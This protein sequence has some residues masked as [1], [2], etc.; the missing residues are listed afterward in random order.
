MPEYR[1]SREI[2]TVKLHFKKKKL[3]NVFFKQKRGR[4]ETQ[5]TIW[6]IEVMKAKKE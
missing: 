1:L 2:S 6:N 4:E 5:N 3:G